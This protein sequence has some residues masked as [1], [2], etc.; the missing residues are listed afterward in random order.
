[1]L[2]Y[3]LYRLKFNLSPKLKLT[4]KFPAH[5]DIESTNYCNL[6]CIMCGRSLM[7]ENLGIMDWDVFTKILKQCQDKCSSIKLNWRGEPLIH[8]LL[9]EMVEAAKKK[10]KI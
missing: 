9:P 10:A 7:P 8:P 3:L 1:M 2:K 6:D 5:I 4:T